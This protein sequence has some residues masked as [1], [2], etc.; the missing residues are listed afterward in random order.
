[1]GEAVNN[2]DVAPKKS[3]FKSLKSEF[4]KITWP[5]RKSLVKQTIAVIVITVILG[6]IIAGVDAVFQVGINWML[7]IG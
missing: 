7:G 2:V 1:M 3:K 4:K 5:D 6:L